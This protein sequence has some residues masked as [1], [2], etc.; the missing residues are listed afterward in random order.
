[1]EGQADLKALEEV[2]RN[3]SN[4]FESQYFLGSVIEGA[5]MGFVFGMPGFFVLSLPLILAFGARSGTLDL[6]SR[7]K[8]GMTELASMHQG[9]SGLV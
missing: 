3:S 5:E 7:L 4:F 2:S 8:N 1:V 6:N 9:A